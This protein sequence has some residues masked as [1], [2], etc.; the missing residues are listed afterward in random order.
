MFYFEL[1]FFP[2]YLLATTTSSGHC[3][4]KLYA[5]ECNHNNYFEIEMN[6]ITLTTTTT[7][8]MMMMTTM[9]TMTMPMTMMT[10]MMISNTTCY[11]PSSFF[12]PIINLFSSNNK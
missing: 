12:T 8:M 10:M 9:M 7:M 11:N 1:F 2:F 4:F 3:T 6:V 5:V